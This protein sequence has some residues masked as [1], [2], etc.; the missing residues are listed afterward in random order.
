MLDLITCIPFPAYES[1]HVTDFDDD[2]DLSHCLADLSAMR[3]PA[4]ILSMSGPRTLR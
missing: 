2:S 4:H 3:V 1:W